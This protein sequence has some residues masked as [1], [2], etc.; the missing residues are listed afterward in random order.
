MMKIN[1]NSGFTL[2]EVIISTLIIS[3][4]M[5]IIVPTFTSI[6]EAKSVLDKGGAREMR[7]AQALMSLMQ[8]DLKSAFISERSGE[9]KFIL[10]NTKDLDGKSM[11]ELYFTSFSYHQ[12][13]DLG[14]FS[15]QCEIGYFIKEEDEKKTLYRREYKAID[16]DIATG[17]EPIKL[18]DSIDYFNVVAYATGFDTA[19]EF[20]EDIEPP[21]L[22]ITPAGLLVK[23]GLK[24]ADGKVRDFETALTLPMYPA[25]N[26]EGDGAGSGDGDGSGAD[27]SGADGSDAG[28]GD[29]G[30]G[31]GG[32]ERDGHD[33]DDT[34]AK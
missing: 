8:N 6:M 21:E 14:K 15:D 32:A 19:N 28:D 24:G 34:S 3:I 23:F 2:I 26:A 22:N 12:M 18:T 30:S 11:D 7:E 16:A 27:G 1:K 33:A 29:N 31:D 5:M 25:D 20:G 4:I 13:G 9:K 17:G 10:M